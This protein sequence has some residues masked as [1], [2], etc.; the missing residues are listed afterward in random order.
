MAS[1]KTAIG[2]FIA[3]LSRYPGIVALFGFVSGVAS[4]LLVER[5]ESLAQIIAAIM[6]VSWCGLVP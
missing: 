4:F 2:Y 3:L 6:L 1:L 5:Q